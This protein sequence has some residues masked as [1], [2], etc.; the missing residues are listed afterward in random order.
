[1]EEFR[2]QYPERTRERVDLVGVPVPEAT[3]HDFLYT[4]VLEK[5]V[6][7]TCDC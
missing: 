2:S 5:H 7:Q 4:F 1:M 3:T 6:M